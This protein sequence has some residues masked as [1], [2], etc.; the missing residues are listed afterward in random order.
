MPRRR[1]QASEGSANSR[2]RCGRSYPRNE[3]GRCHAALRERTTPA[4]RL[5]QLCP[6]G[7]GEA[8]HAALAMEGNLPAFPSIT[9]LSSGD[10]P[11]RGQRGHGA[12][13]V[14]P[15]GTETPR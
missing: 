2:T 14:S 6:S 9:Y 10:C 15:E 13:S 4:H 12:S 8:G 5:T 1:R 3:P 11:E 7:L